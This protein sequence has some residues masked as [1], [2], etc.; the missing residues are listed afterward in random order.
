MNRASRYLSPETNA[1]I[2]L[3]LTSH[4]SLPALRRIPNHTLASPILS[5]S[6][7]I[8]FVFFF[9]FLCLEALKTVLLLVWH[10]ELT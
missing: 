4:F 2:T 9:F 10:I 1:F 7:H 3:S 5:V 6:P 8:A